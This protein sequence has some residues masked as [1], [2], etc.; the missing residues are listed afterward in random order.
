MFIFS[1][2][3]LNTNWRMQQAIF[4][5]AIHSAK[6]GNKNGDGSVDDRVP[7]EYCGRRFDAKVA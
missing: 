4:R 2:G 3:K 1:G 7:C 6:S 5:A